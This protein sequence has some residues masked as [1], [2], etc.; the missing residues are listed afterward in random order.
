MQGTTGLLII[1]LCV[2]CTVTAFLVFAVVS[3]IAKIMIFCK[4]GKTA[5]IVDPL[6]TVWGKESKKSHS[7]INV[8]LTMDGIASVEKVKEIFNK[9]LLDVTDE[10]GSPLYKKFR[11]IITIEYG[12]FIWKDALA[13]D[14]NNHVRVWKDP[15][16]DNNDNDDNVGENQKYTRN[17]N[18]STDDR[19]AG[20][21]DVICRY[22][23]ENDWSSFMDPTQPKWEVV[24]LDSSYVRPG[25]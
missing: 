12:Y 3:T 17:R 16:E 10:E 9:K 11:Q 6:D 1:L 19:Y 13:F 2:P 15:F 7:Y 4:Y 14:I 23:N 20:T 5:T 21:E 24:I 8:S 22:M 18:I 25:Q